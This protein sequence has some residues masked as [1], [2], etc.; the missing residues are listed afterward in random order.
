MSVLPFFIFAFKQLLCF[1]VLPWTVCLYGNL[2]CSFVP[3]T[4]V[5]VT[6]P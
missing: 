5:P 1:P 3:V 6:M 2:T 4:L